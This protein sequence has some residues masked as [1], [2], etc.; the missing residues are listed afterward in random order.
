MTNFNEMN[1]EQ[2]GAA[3]TVA[4][5]YYTINPTAD[6]TATLDAIAAAMKAKA[7]F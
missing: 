2:L 1:V 3:W 5:N 6:A 7:G 4:F